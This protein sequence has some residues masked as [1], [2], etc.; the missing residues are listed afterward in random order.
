M[1][2]LQKKLEEEQAAQKETKKASLKANKELDKGRKAHEKELDAFASRSWDMME[3]YQDY[4]RSA[5]ADTEFSGEC[6][7]EEFMTW[8]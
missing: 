4:L 8:L 6:T 7:M 1:N 2:A 5:G 3:R